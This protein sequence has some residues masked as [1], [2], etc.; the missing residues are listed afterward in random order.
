MPGARIIGKRG[1]SRLSA[2]FFFTAALMLTASAAWARFVGGGGAGVIIVVAVASICAALGAYSFVA[3][4]KPEPNRPR[5]HHAPTARADTPPIE[6]LPAPH[7]EERNE[8]RY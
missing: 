8:Q 4:R 5:P 1:L 6:I 3:G 7:E 2:A